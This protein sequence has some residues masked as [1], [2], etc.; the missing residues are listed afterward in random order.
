MKYSNSA[1]AQ[2]NYAVQWKSLL[3]TK[4]H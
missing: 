2:T 4:N 3:T 1:I